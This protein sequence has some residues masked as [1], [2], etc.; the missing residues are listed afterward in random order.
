MV[1]NYPQWNAQED[2]FLRENY[3][4]LNYEEMALK[5]NRTKRAVGARCQAL[6]LTAN[7]SPAWTESEINWLKENFDKYTKSE[8]AKKLKRTPNAVQ[9]K[10]NRLGL[11]RP[12]EYFY[13]INY[14]EN[15][16]TEDKAYWLGFIYADGYIYQTPRNCGLGIEL[17]IKDIEHLKKFNKC[18]SG[19]LP[20]ATRWREPNNLIK[21]RRQ[22]C[23]IRLYRKKIIED[24]NRYGVLFNKTYK[25][26]HLPNLSKDL[27]PSFI[28]GFFDGDGS[29]FSRYNKSYKDSILN[30]NFTNAS[31]TLL[32][33]IREY[34]YT[35]HIYSYI[36][37]QT[38]K[39]GQT[40]P[41]YQ[42]VINGMEN[43]IDFLELLYNDS[44]IYLE[45]KYKYY[46]EKLIEYNLKDRI[47]NSKNCKL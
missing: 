32:Q 35:H 3:N 22:V 2:A 46:C 28:R 14:F 38:D 9:V 11:K 26:L 13:D 24:L 42:L 29:V 17:A 19:N 43:T 6:K 36:N 33:E 40:T 7:K 1:K 5:L 10:A 16:D 39:V 27:M 44:N 8:L 30:A 25:D 37:E 34:L 4:K 15:I 45:R 41:L 31:L 18:I 20:I 47:N 23:S 21:T 12:D